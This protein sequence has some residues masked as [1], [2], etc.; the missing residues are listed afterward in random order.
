VIVVDSSVWIAN[1]RGAENT[2][3]QKLL[4]LI[5]SDDDQLLIGD[6]V[7]LEVLQGARNE[8]HAS[9]IERG[10]RQ[11]PI[12]PMMD[13]SLATLA[14]FNY[15]QLRARGFTIRK[16]IVMIIGTFCIDRGHRLLHD[17][18][19]FDPMARHLGLKVL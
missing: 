17:D 9:L 14:A 4:A 18:G 3:T 13:E 7:L 5:D 12:V 2:A 10:I 15:R 16:T 1:L 11:Y 6:L 19:D 8:G